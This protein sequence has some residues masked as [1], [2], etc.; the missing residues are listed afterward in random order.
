MAHALRTRRK[1]LA[2]DIRYQWLHRVGAQP[3]TGLLS[4]EGIRLGYA[5]K[6]EGVWRIYVLDVTFPQRETARA[7][8][9]EIARRAAQFKLAHFDLTVKGKAECQ[10]I[11]AAPALGPPETGQYAS[12]AFS[13]FLP[14]RKDA[15]FSPAQGPSPG[16][17][18]PRERLLDD[19]RSRVAAARDHDDYGPVMSAA[20]AE[21]ADRLRLSVPD[22]GSD[23]EVAWAVGWLDWLRVTQLGPRKGDHDATL[24]VELFRN[25]Y[26]AIRR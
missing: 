23:L 8:A 16:M 24:A 20:G 11:A 22:P 12:H 4:S 18:G 9:E 6:R 25:V 13:W 19:V 26:P 14:V 1:I 7:A 10:Q 21:A 3:K 15:A 5:T 2:G 17:D